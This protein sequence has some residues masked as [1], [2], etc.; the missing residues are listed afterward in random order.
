VLTLVGLP[1]ASRPSFVTVGLDSLSVMLDN[2]AAALRYSRYIKIK[3]DADSDRRM[4]D[5]QAGVCV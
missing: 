5:V 3:V 4:W 1:A 2:L